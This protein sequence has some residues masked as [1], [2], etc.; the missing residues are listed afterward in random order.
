MRWYR[1]ESVPVVDTYDMTDTLAPHADEVVTRT[2]LYDDVPF[3]RAAQVGDVLQIWGI[4]GAGTGHELHIS[5][6]R[7]NVNDFTFTAL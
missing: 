4:V 1:N 2:L 5:R 7:I 6:L 3:V